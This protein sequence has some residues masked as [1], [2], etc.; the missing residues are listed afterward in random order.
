MGQKRKSPKHMREINAYVLA[1]LGSAV[2]PL[3]W[4]GATDNGLCLSMSATFVNVTPAR[5]YAEGNP[6]WTVL[7]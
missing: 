3:L 5:T 2:S 4:D 6:R 1:C 7:P